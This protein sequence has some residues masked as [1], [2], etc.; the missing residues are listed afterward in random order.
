MA[1]DQQ[2]ARIKDK[3]EMHRWIDELPD[4]ARAIILVD[5]GGDKHFEYHELGELLIAE[6]VYMCESLKWEVMCQD[7]DDE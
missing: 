1:L 7:E 4:D 6:I 5:P 2:V 3:D